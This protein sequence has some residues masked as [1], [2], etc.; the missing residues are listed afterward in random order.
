[1]KKLFL[2]GTMLL[3]GIMGYAQSKNT[4]YSTTPDTQKNQVLI[5]TRDGGMRYYNMEAVSSI[6][7]DDN[8]IVTVN[9]P[10]GSYKF[11]NNVTDIS[12]RKAYSGVV[13]NAAGKVAITEARGWFESAYVKFELMEGAKSYNVYV[14]GGRLNGYTK[15]DAQLVRNYGSY[16]RADV[17]GMV[18][19]S[20]YAIKVVPVDENGQELTDAANEATGIAIAAHNRSGFAHKERTEGVGAYNNDGSLKSNARVVYVTKSNA[21]TVSLDIVTDSKGKTTTYTGFQAIINGYQKGYETRPLA[22][23]LVGTISASDC[24]EF[25]SSAEGIQVKGK[26]AYSPMNITIE[27][28]GD[29]A[30]TTGFGF[31]IRN[32]SS[33][34]LRNFANMLCMDDAVSIDTD[35]EHVWVHH[36]DLFYG[37]TGG[38]A[39]QAKGDGTID[40]KGDSRYITVS[41]NHLWDSGKASLCGM[42]SE[43]GP[44]WITYHHNWFDHS[45]SRHP[46][47]RTMSVH[48][49]NNYF[50]GNAKYGVGAAYRS[51]AFVEANYFR[52]CKYPMLISLQ[53]SDVAT[54]PKGTFSGEEGGMIKSYA[55]VIKDATR[56]VTYQQNATE[57]DAYEAQSRDE[58][59]PATVVAKSGG[60]GYDNFD[61]D[62]ALFYTYTPDAAIDVPAIV[63]GWLGA[64]R[65][66]H[67]DFQ[68]TF[69]NATE[70]KNYEVIAA[71]KTKLQ[72]YKSSLVGFFGEDVVP[73]DNP[74]EEPGETPG[75][76][77]GDNPNNPVVGGT[78]ILC[79]FTEKGVPSSNL[80]T[81]SGN[82][83]NSKGTAT[84]DGQSLKNCLKME[85][86]TSV[87]FTLA[88]AMKMTLYF[89][90]T[91]TASIMIDGTKIS[92]SGST[93]TTTLESGEHE[94]TKDKS[95][96]LFAIKLE[97]IE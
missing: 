46:R 94:L 55:N 90:D 74:S 58:Q 15:I 18:A 3:S 69:D 71:L 40:L 96:N 80:F 83:S 56:Y 12:F 72:N 60:R 85:K 17:L 92:G 42:K 51:N 82:G 34:E 73:G 4:D 81:V 10:E 32:T 8:N 43:S 64:G 20:D 91:E 63:T 88:T 30:V 13:A 35:N 70:D 29:D 1:M 33:V 2:I 65:I 66:G 52:S 19:A 54:D 16:G 27:G 45:D 75:D 89:A 26:N 49:F 87:K 76:N 67:G 44:N 78:T 9:Q 86:A 11:D 36:L 93:Y 31:L 28:V 22:V 6:D 50:D 68:W 53:G 37:K 97:P 59:V 84:V 41:Y 23:R 39:D 79:T 24:D 5:G 57:F 77:P 21:K 47:I 7:I 62:A 38:D 61:T 25:L 48:V 14:K 95:V